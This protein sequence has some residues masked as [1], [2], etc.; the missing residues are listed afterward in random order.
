MQRLL[1]G[2]FGNHRRIGCFR[3]PHELDDVPRLEFIGTLR[4]IPIEWVL[5]RA[6]VVEERGPAA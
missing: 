1:D 6:F 5:E 3:T 2:L 4:L